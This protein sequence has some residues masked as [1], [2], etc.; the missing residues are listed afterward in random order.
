[1]EFLTLGEPEY[2]ERLRMI[3]D[4]PPVLAVRGKIDSLAQPLIAI[5]GARRLP[6]VQ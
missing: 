3:D 4:P 5:V 2:P 1:M 6:G